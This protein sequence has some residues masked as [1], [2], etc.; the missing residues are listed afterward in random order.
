MKTDDITYFEAADD[1]TRTEVPQIVQRATSLEE[2]ID[3]WCIE[4]RGRLCVGAVL[5][6]DDTL[7]RG[8]VGI[9]FDRPIT[10][11][12]LA[13]VVVSRS[14]IV[15]AGS[16]PACID[17]FVYPAKTGRRYADFDD[18]AL[19]T[20]FDDVGLS[21]SDALMS[22]IGAKSTLLPLV[23]LFALSESG[24]IEIRQTDSA[25]F[26]EEDVADDLRKEGLDMR[27]YVGL[28]PC[29]MGPSSKHM[30]SRVM[31]DPIYCRRTNA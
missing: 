15:S 26:E 10:G 23:L 27:D 31:F 21:F 24:M 7:M 25:Y 8:V 4:R 13:C 28:H 17:S 1:T 3:H 16:E 2:I 14:E 22:R 11:E 19:S 6:D 5:D 18:K 30:Q 20:W 9:T 29:Y 12:E